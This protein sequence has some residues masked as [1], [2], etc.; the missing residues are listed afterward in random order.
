MSPDRRR[1]DKNFRKIF[2]GR[3]RA[4]RRP[5]RFRQVSLRKKLAN[6]T[7][8]VERNASLNNL[9]RRRR[10]MST[11]NK[12]SRWNRFEIA[13]NEG[14]RPE[15]AALRK[16]W[17][18]N[19]GKTQGLDG[20]GRL[21]PPGQTNAEKSPPPNRASAEKSPPPNRANAEKSPP[22][23][24]ANAEKSPPPN[25]ANA[26]ENDAKTF[27]IA[28]KTASKRSQAVVP[29]LWEEARRSQ[30]DAAAKKR[31]EPTL[32]SIK[33]SKTLEFDKST[34]EAKEFPFPRRP[35]TYR[36]SDPPRRFDDPRKE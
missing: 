18:E 10:K 14:K 34:L 25:R 24:R 8:S 9:T 27:A 1:N 12:K 15:A 29:G 13:F 22:L 35:R 20:L 3:K 30:A 6:S 23:N 2:L 17:R 26:E 33:L 32:K 5:R 11:E 31:V 16:D 7:A 4:S 36:S 28:K 21:A 19:L